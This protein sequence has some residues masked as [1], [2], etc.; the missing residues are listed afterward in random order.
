[1]VILLHGECFLYMIIIKP[2]FG[3]QYFCWIT[4]SRHPGLSKN[5]SSVGS[6]HPNSR[7]QFPPKKPQVLMLWKII[8]S[9]KESWSKFF[10]PVFFF[11]KEEKRESDSFLFFNLEGEEPPHKKLWVCKNLGFKR[12]CEMIFWGV[13]YFSQPKTNMWKIPSSKV[14]GPND[15]R[16]EIH[17]F[18]THRFVFVAVTLTIRFGFF[19]GPWFDE[20]FSTACWAKVSKKNL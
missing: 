14:G 19:A 5:P 6:S 8:L 16:I 15:F 20:F 7:Q 12:K 18:Q 10:A 3:S 11:G 17:G 13:R 4:F 9:S 1:M 2:P